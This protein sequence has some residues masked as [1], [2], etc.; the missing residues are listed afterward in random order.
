MKISLL[1]FSLLSLLQIT[2]TLTGCS[3]LSMRTDD[4]AWNE[5]VAEQKAKRTP[6]QVHEKSIKMPELQAILDQVPARKF[7][8]A[9][10]AADASLLGYCYQEKLSLYFD[11]SFQKVVTRTPAS[12]YKTEQKVFFD[13]WSLEKIKNHVHT[14]HQMLLSGLEL[15]AIDH[16]KELNSMCEN[17]PIEL[18]NNLTFNYYHGGSTYVPRG[19]YFCLNSKWEDDANLLLTETLDRLGLKIENKDART[20][21]LHDQVFPTYQEETN[22]ILKQHEKKEQSLIKAELA[23]LINSAKDGGTK[24]KDCVE[25]NVEFW[26]PTLREKFHYLKIESLLTEH[27]Q[28]VCKTS[29]GS[30]S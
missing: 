18:G 7:L 20:W 24:R 16:I 10:S 3:P 19:Y 15:R 12:V 2:L 26:S 28:Q 6:A 27:F 9:C 22:A 13:E 8:F 17:H 5:Y 4:Q 23:G 1:I 30:T 14:F 25:A 11:Q 21:I 29:G